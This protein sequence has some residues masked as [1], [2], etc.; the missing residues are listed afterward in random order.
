MLNRVH[1]A[2]GLFLL[3][4]CTTGRMASAQE[5][6]CFDL[7]FQGPGS[8]RL[9]MLR[10]PD[11]GGGSHLQG[12]AA[13]DVLEI[14]NGRSICA[15]TP[16]EACTWVSTL[17][18]SRSRI[19]AEADARLRQIRNRIQQ[20]R[21]LRAEALALEASLDKVYDRSEDNIK[22]SIKFSLTILVG[23]EALSERI[24]EGVS[25]FLISKAIKD[26][27]LSFVADG[28]V[29]IKKAGGTSAVT[30]R[31]ARLTLIEAVAAAGADVISDLWV[32]PSL[33][34]MRDITGHV[35]DAA[36]RD[37]AKQMSDA[38]AT[39]MLASR[40][41]S[42]IRSDIPRIKR[43]L[44]KN[45]ASCNGLGAAVD[46]PYLA[47]PAFDVASLRLLS[48][49]LA[50]AT[51]SVSRSIAGQ[52]SAASDLR[53]L[54]AQK[55]LSENATR[56]ERALSP[57]LGSGTDAAVDAMVGTFTGGPAVGPAREAWQTIQLAQEALLQEVGRR[58]LRTTD[59]TRLRQTVL[60][61]TTP[62]LSPS[63]ALRK[64]DSVMNVSQLRAAG[65]STLPDDGKR[66]ELSL[67]VL[68]ASLTRDS[69]AARI[70]EQLSGSDLTASVRQ[71]L[72]IGNASGQTI[73]DQRDKA[74]A[75]RTN[76]TQF[77]SA[78][79]TTL[80]RLRE[81]VPT[82]LENPAAVQG[83]LAVTNDVSA[84]INDFVRYGKSIDGAIA[85]AATLSKV[86]VTA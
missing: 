58:A 9:Y 78:L 55:E 84:A 23:A 72:A 39:M 43:Y 3:L 2:A 8:F 32:K 47:V 86:S 11:P 10:V 66:V 57:I 50:A 31:L 41:Q 85:R 79:Q 44:S 16:A 5:T 24:W 77:Q 4:F 18:D 27:V 83:A 52:V 22:E 26:D 69:A 35:S 25:G 54:A 74:A 65:F 12:F 6:R 42:S 46:S 76:A 53:P 34:H 63:A 67:M 38:L 64:I 14:A 51:D 30:K 73:D 33:D 28:T 75:V 71:L 7:R 80:T 60:E 1:R 29:A 17:Q 61:A 68:D 20:S 21:E 13:A 62:G 70:A 36:T 82:R 19:T 49:G 37:L 59:P 15:A 56:A 45:N 81:A 48:D 40:F